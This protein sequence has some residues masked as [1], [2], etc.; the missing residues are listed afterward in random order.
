MFRAEEVRDLAQGWYRVLEA[1]VRHA[2]RPR[3]GG[4]SPCDLPLLALSQA[5]I[6]RLESRHP[7]LEDLL[8][9]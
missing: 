6:E 5:E 8:A 9:L 1:L 2:E 4:R 7:Q 3:A